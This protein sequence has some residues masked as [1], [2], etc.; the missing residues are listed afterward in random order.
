MA[1]AP[2]MIRLRSTSRN[3]TGSAEI[4]RQIGGQIR[5][6]RNLP[7]TQFATRQI[8][9]VIHEIIDVDRNTPVRILLEHRAYACDHLVRAVP[10]LT[11]AFEGGAR[12]AQIGLFFFEPT[13]T[14]V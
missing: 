7:R 12:L 13:R 9:H 14:G 11:D 1:S 5:A 6:E 3:W 2:F 8:E 10:I 4:G